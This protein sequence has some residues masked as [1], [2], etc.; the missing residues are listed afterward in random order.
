[1]MAVFALDFSL[2]YLSLYSV[3]RVLGRMSIDF[4]ECLGLDLPV[5]GSD[6]L[7]YL[8]AC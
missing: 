3:A 8:Q 4:T 7:Y 5:Q 6:E 1:M 2:M